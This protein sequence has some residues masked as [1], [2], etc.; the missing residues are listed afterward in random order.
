MQG[1]ARVRVCVCVLGG[2]VPL[3]LRRAKLDQLRPSHQVNS[4]VSDK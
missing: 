4:D 2:R 1:T 3:L